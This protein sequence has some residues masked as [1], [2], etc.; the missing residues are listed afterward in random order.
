MFL[1][2]K[3]SFVSDIQMLKSIFSDAFALPEDLKDLIFILKD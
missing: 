1:M 3:I 2:T